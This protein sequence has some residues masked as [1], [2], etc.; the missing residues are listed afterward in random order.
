MA[1]GVITPSHTI[2]HCQNL[3]SSGGICPQWPCSLGPVQPQ[4]PTVSC[5]GRKI[6]HD[7]HPRIQC[8]GTCCLLTHRT[9]P[10]TSTSL[11]TMH[12]SLRQWCS[13]MCSFLRPR[14]GP[15]PVITAGHIPGGCC[16]LVH[17]ERKVT[18]EEGWEHYVPSPHP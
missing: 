14:C 2:H 1:Q 3:R 5:T 7:Q 17:V 16:S 18:R 12:V 15:G 9:H 6:L 11:A 13:Y 8:C 10:L 4:M